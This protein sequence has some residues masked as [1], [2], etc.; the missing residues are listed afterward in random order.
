MEVKISN[1]GGIVTSLKVP[2][3]HGKLGDVV[4]GYDTLAGYLKASP[5]FGAIIGRYANRIAKGR[6]TL[7]GKEYKLATNNGA[8]RIARRPQRLR[9]GRLEADTLDEDP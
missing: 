7:D 4:L 9:Q 1:Y 3:R 8:Q 6:F 2:D 5:Y